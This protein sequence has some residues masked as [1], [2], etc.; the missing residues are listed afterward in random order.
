MSSIRYAGLPAYGST[1]SLQLVSYILLFSFC[2][3]EVSIGRGGIS[4][5]TWLRDVVKPSLA[6]QPETSSNTS[7][8]HSRSSPLLQYPPVPRSASDPVFRYK[9]GR[10]STIR[11]PRSSRPDEIA[12][13]A[14]ST[15]RV[16]ERRTVLRRLLIYVLNRCGG[17]VD[18]YKMGL[19][20]SH[21]LFSWS[22]TFL[23]LHLQQVLAVA[24]F[25]VQ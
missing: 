6:P 25:I 9:R 16:G 23:A 11:K 22:S 12:V 24:L 18:I 13:V 15:R 5:S 3:Y 4:F 19:S 17:L 10:C 8:L 21:R 7:D 1:S 20:S 2:R 14:R